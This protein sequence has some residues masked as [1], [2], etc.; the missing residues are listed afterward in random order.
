MYRNYQWVGIGYTALVLCIYIVITA[1]VVIFEVLYFADGNCGRIFTILSSRFTCILPMECILTKAK[2]EGENFT[3]SEVKI[4]YLIAIQL[5]SYTI[6]YFSLVNKIFMDSSI[7][8]L[9]FQITYIYV[10]IK[11]KD[12][13]VNMLQCSYI[14]SS[15]LTLHAYIKIPI[16]YS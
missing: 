4:N 9:T 3:G 5:A 13:I 2:F 12:I 14:A 1:H 6:E 11:I 16:E 8:T 15:F 7:Q 10:Y